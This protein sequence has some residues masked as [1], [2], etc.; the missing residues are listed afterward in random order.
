MIVCIADLAHQLRSQGEVKSIGCRSE[1][2]PGARAIH[3][4]PKQRRATSAVPQA[5]M[6]VNTIHTNAYKYMSI[7]TDTNKYWRIQTP[8]RGPDHVTASA[9]GHRPGRRNQWTFA[10]N[11][12]LIPVSAAF[13][14]ARRGS[15]DRPGLRLAGPPVTAFKLPKAA[16]L[17]LNFQ[18]NYILT[19]CD[20]FSVLFNVLLC[21]KLEVWMGLNHDQSLRVRVQRDDCDWALVECECVV[22]DTFGH[23]FPGKIQPYWASTTQLG[24]KMRG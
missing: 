23:Y 22:M 15:C 4:Q 5:N 24:I 9:P 2:G 17:N 14:M 18:T 6:I 1:P 10:E 19:W 7:R 12:L 8:S 20:V 13:S 16:N 21:C 3:W 11:V